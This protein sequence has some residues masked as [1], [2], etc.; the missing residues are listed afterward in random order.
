MSV[1]LVVSTTFPQYEGDPRGEFIL[2]H[3]EQVASRGARV[4]VLVPRTGWCRGALAGPC[5]IVR[6]AY[7]PRV[8]S[9]LTGNFGILENIREQPWRAA[10][11]PPLWIGLRRAVQRELA[12]GDVGRVV[13]HMLLPAGWIV[14]DECSR[15]GVPFDLFGHG[16]DVDVLLRLPRPLLRRFVARIRSAEAVRFPSAEKRERF[17]RALGHR[18]D[19][20]RLVVEPMVHCVAPPDPIAS[21]T[22]PGSRTILYLGRLIPQKGVGDLMIV[23]AR[24]QPRPRL[25]IAGDGPHRRRLQRLARRLGLEVRFHGFLH[26]PAVHALFAAADVLCVPSREVAGLSEGTPLVI[27]EAFA[28]HVPVVATAV[29]GIPE[30]HRPDGALALVAPGDLLALQHALE[31][32]LGRGVASPRSDPAVHTRRVG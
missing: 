30:L 11:V 1:T 23:A 2:R 20:T 25:E 12:R 26:R 17:R 8:L 24:M 22:R 27:R 28:H 32:A 29:G 10:L 21:P 13:A 14:A 5:E 15:R 6:F 3:W 16:T 4:R 19:P 9:T 18:D 7:A 31:D